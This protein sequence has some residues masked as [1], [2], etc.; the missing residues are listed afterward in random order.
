MLVD[1]FN[2]SDAVKVGASL[3][4]SFLPKVLPENANRPSRNL[5]A[6]VQKLL[7]Q[8]MR[9][10][11]PLKLNV[12]KRAKLLGSFKWTLLEKGVD[13][14]T[15]ENVTQLLLQQISG[16]PPDLAAGAG[17]AATTA[18]SRLR[19]LPLLLSE[20]E[21][22]YTN[23]EYAEA[24]ELL[25]QAVATDPRHAIA[26]ARLGAALFN[27]GRY[28]EAE[29]EFRRAIELKPDC[30]DAQLHL[31]TLLHMKGDFAAAETALRRAVKRDPRN[32]E[33]LVGLGLSIAVY[34][35]PSDAKE[36]FER[37]QRLKPRDASVLC[38]FGWLASVE[39]RFTEAEE[40]YRTAL[41]V[42][43]R[44]SAAW[45]SLTRLRR[46]TAAD[47]DWLDGAERTLAAGVP[48]LEESRLRFA[49]GKYFDDL[50]NFSR[51]FE[52][53]RRGNDLHK[54]IVGA[55]NKDA[56]EKFIND[57]IRVYT[58]ERLARA[59][60]GASESARP[61][62]VTGM[63]RSGTSLVEQIVATHPD[64]V[65]A[66]E[67]DFW[68]EAVRRHHQALLSGLPDAA[69]TRKLVDGY[70]RTLA[71]HSTD[72]ARVVDKATFNS[73]HLGLIHAA[74]PKSRII[75]LRR[76]PIDV[77]LSC[78]FQDFAN[79][80]TFSFDL[81][82]LAHY[83]REHHRLIQHW[84]SVLPAG[85]VLEVPY[86]ELVA[87]SEA[88]T[89]RIIDFIGLEWDPRCLEFQHTKRAVVTASSWQVRQ[90]INSR[91]VGRWRN[92]EKHIKPLL[93]LRALA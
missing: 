55:Y 85:T 57:M 62:F 33:A 90:K 80:A 52:H 47:K 58:P 8:A 61:V 81:A 91:S 75:Y 39:G 3:A 35:Q 24:I 88:W 31:G 32:T 78:Y 29:T 5:R 56:R 83:Y 49:M 74:F 69:L 60:E 17:E 9:E 18:T 25:Q 30:A 14:S 41:E 65:G 73:D 2:A 6:D 87:D 40:L 22:R 70:L 66:G 67:L 84:Q 16:L 34:R 51:A 93:E 11:R 63:P 72:A 59:I 26:H 68:T 64:A 15:V 79:A 45:A 27:V 7:Q 50:G 89:R 43:P 38:A 37:A 21:V 76:D 12:F 4:T 53:Y 1:W 42:D 44:K 82:D 20:A 46:M 92:Y 86:A 36:W 13:Q 77:C 54:A 10:V 28:H 19:R 23:G 71:G 48:P